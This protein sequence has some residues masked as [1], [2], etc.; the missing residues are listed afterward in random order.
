MSKQFST[1]WFNEYEARQRAKQH[2]LVLSKENAV[3]KESDLHGDIHEECRRRGWIP[4][5]SS[6]AHKTRRKIGEPDFIIATNDGRTLYVECKSRTGKIT[7]AQ[8]ATLHWLLHNKQIAFVVTSIE[9]FRR[10]VD[11][12]TETP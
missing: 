2:P 1:E 5:T 7:P 9:E 12:A 3:E 6:M 10:I 8:Q 11:D 4:F